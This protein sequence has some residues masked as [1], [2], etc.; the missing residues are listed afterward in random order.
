MARSGIPEGVVMRTSGHRTRSVFERY[1]VV[2][3]GGL[4]AAAA[5]IEQAD[6][7]HQLQLHRNCG[8]LH[9]H[10]GQLS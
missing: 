1:N 2:S 9:N 4:K 10:A 5:K 8:K 6:R 3:Q 7:S